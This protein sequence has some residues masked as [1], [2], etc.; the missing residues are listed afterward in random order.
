M[1]KETTKLCLAWLFFLLYYLITY[2]Y[3]SKQYEF[4]LRFTHSMPYGPIFYGYFFIK[5]L[6]LVAAAWLGYYYAKGFYL[7]SSFLAKVPNW[8]F[9]LPLILVI[10][11]HLGYVV[12]L[13]HLNPI[14]HSFY[15]LRLS[16]NLLIF[17][18]ALVY[19]LKKMTLKGE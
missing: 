18:T 17:F 3:P 13:L 7:K 1:T 19:H 10:L 12:G 16:P 11:Y 4:F 2:S 5:V 14:F 8:I 6:S 15:Y 9:A